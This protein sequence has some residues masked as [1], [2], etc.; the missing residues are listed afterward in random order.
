[1]PDHTTA[2]PAPMTTAPAEQNSLKAPVRKRHILVVDDEKNIRLTVQHSLMAANYDVD[3]AADGLEGLTKFRDDHYDLV[4]MDLRM[5][6]INGIEMLREIRE[7][8]KHTAAIVITAY[9]TIDT[10]LEAFSLGVSDYIRKP[11]SPNDVRET[12][13]RVLA[14]ET[15]DTGQPAQQATVNLEAARKALA[16]Q[17][18]PR[19]IELATRAVSL[20]SNDPDAYAFLGML[21]HLDGNP[22]AAEQSFHEAL[23]VDPQH[24]LSRD[25][26]FWI[27]SK[28]NG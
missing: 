9:L 1:M 2:T 26:L 8:D 21:Q 25:Y 16:E 17:D 11:F 28:R 12:V 5:P 27:Q 4:L 24:Q 6:Q 23:L 18:I 7:R 3:T 10:L 15:L 14:R 22:K 20:N 19:A 13:R